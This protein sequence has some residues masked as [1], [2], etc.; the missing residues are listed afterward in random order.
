MANKTTRNA[1]G[2][3]NIRKRSDRRWE[4]RYTVGID[5]KTGRQIQKSIY[6]NTQK[7]VRMRL[8]E[9]TSELDNGTYIE[10]CKMSMDQ[11][12]DV[13]LEEYTTD[14]KPLTLVSYKTH[15][16]NNI[17]PYLGQIKLSALD[18]PTIQRLYNRLLRGMD[19]R[20]PLSPKTI[21]DLHG[22]LHRALQQAV[23]LGMIRVN[24]ASAC[25]PPR[26]EKPAIHPLA[27]DNVSKFLSAIRSDSCEPIFQLGLFTGMRQGEL[28]GLMWT[29]VN[30]SA[31][32]IFIDKQLQRCYERGKG[33]RFLSPKNGKTR[34]ISVA[35]SVMEIL[36]KHREKQKE[37][38]QQAGPAWEDSQLVFTDEFGHHL[39]PVTVRKHCK[40]ALAAIGQKDVR[41]H[42][43]RHSYAVSSIQ[44]GDSIKMVQENLG[45]A[46][47][48]FTLD[49]YGHV[50]DQMRR[51]SASR[52]EQ[53]IH[54]VTNA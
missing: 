27:D 11:W 34:L 22:V 5:P 36:R 19:D 46:T 53:Y 42:D 8:T 15:A 2:G 26:V 14:I 38:L 18:A 3:G 12:L 54:S 35:P 16:K 6:G 47:A 52:M 1:Q 40:A 44:S 24:P 30:F 31:N 28:L 21:K 48:A 7:E 29:C 37:M 9:V 39:S 13:W 10:P 20:A 51:D 45:H 41:F 23:L 50:S 49:V 25:K 4:A 32:T 43:L 33:Y 17:R